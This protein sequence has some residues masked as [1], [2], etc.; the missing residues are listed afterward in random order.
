MRALIVLLAAL[1]LAATPE[2]TTGRLLVASADPGARL[3]TFADATGVTRVLPV[4]G[5]AERT[6]SRLRPGDEVALS[7]GP[8]PGVVG[9]PDVVL[10]IQT[11]PPSPPAGQAGLRELQIAA[12]ELRDPRQRDR[13]G[14]VRLP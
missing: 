2:R 4:R 13:P 3:I 1:G 8:E 9:G 14:L 7:V 6:L 10:D 5:E 11:L 12:A